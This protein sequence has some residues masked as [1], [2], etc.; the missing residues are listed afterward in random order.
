MVIGVALQHKQQ[1]IGEQKIGV[2]G[3]A[4]IDAFVNTWTDFAPFEPIVFDIIDRFEQAEGHDALANKKPERFGAPE[5]EEPQ[6][7]AARKQAVVDHAV[8]KAPETLLAFARALFF[9]APFFDAPGTAPTAQHSAQIKAV[10]T[11]PQT[12]TGGIVRGGDP[13][14]V[15]IEVLDI[16]MQITDGHQQGLAQKALK[17]I[18]LV[19]QFMG[20]GNAQAARANTHRKR[21]TDLLQA[22]PVL[23]ADQPSA[24]DD[25]AVLHRHLQPGHEF[26]GETIEQGLGLCL[27]GIVQIMAQ[28]KIQNWDQAKD[29]E[30]HGKLRQPAGLGT[31]DRQQRNNVSH[32][33]GQRPQGAVEHILGGGE[34]QGQL[35]GAPPGLWGFIGRSGANIALRNPI[36]HGKF[37]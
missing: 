32:A 31:P 11:L 37:P 22:T 30:W 23:L 20:Q 34:I 5:Q 4:N 15:A 2:P 6:A 21:K 14:M 12:G 16:K 28:D 8:V 36:T 10:K 25:Q 35:H 18:D 17:A 27:T 19:N 29:K 3:V 13:A 1:T 7:K 26:K 33:K 24:A 9:E